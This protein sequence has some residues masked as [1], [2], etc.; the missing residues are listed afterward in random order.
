MNNA[1]IKDLISLSK[2]YKIVEKLT[3]QVIGARTCYNWAHRGL[4][5][6]AG[7]VQK[8]RIVTRL[9]KYATTEAWIEE[10]LERIA[11]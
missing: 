7:Q 6:K 5:D 11:R 10:F 4:E 9:G 8:L 1:P 2:A 3:D